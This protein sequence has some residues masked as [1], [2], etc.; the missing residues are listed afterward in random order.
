MDSSFISDM[1]NLLKKTSSIFG[2]KPI[3]LPLRGDKRIASV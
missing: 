2:S 1:K 3:A